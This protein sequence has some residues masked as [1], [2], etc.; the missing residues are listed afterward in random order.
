MKVS[1]F[2]SMGIR[3]SVTAEGVLKYS[4]PKSLK[5]KFLEQLRQYKTA[6]IE[7]LAGSEAGSHRKVTGVTDNRKTMTD[8]TSR[9]HLDYDGC[10]GYDGSKKFPIEKIHTCTEAIY[11]SPIEKEENTHHTRHTHHSTNEN[12]DLTRHV[13]HHDPSQPVTAD[14][15]AKEVGTEERKTKTA[16]KTINEANPKIDLTNTPTCTELDEQTSSSIRQDKMSY[17]FKMLSKRLDRQVEVEISSG[18]DR[19]VH[20][21]EVSYSQDEIRTLSDKK[22]SAN[23]LRAIHNAKS[24]F[25]GGCFLDFLPIVGIFKQN[26]SIES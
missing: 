9:N 13:I 7:E 21:D 12:N 23:D 8:V 15:G 26:I 5:G 2:E 3:L 14:H 24:I 20:V 10:D 18:K 22:I 17:K 4:A 6:L 16:L 11:V 19:E 1:E 25:D